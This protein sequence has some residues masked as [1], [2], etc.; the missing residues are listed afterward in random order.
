MICAR[1]GSA[2]PPG[3]R[4]CGSCGA[5]LV[6]ASAPEQ[7][8][9]RV[10]VVFC[11]VVGSTGLGE[12]LDPEVLRGHLARWFEEVRA[13][14]ERHGGSVE[15]FVGDA[16]MAVFGIPVA[17]EDDALRA[18]R[19]VTEIRERMPALAGEL[20][21]PLE[22]RMG[23]NTG[24]VAAGVGETLATG[25][26]V[27]VAARLQQAADRG[28]ILVG[29]ETVRLARDAV[30]T[31]AVEPIAVKGRTEP[32]A[33]FRLLRVDPAAE[34]IT[35]RLDAP[36]VGRT[37]ERD[38]LA[39]AWEDVGAGNRCVLVT[40]LGPA[41][42]G[43]SRLAADLLAGL[44]SEALVA[45]GRCLPYGEGIT[46]R[47]LVEILVQLGRTPDEVIGT[48][49]EST[50]LAFRRLLEEEAA[51]RPVV[52]VFDD[53]HWA[54]PL[55][56]DLVE[57]VAD[58]SRDAP[59]LLLCLARQE[60]LEIRPAWGGGKVN[61]I[62]ILL[63]PL[64]PEACEELLDELLGEQQ[65]ELELRGRILAA[66]DGNPLY[67]EEI[68][69][70]LDESGDSGVAVPPTIHALLQ[71]RLDRLD[72]TER[73]ALQRGAVEGQVFHRGAVMELAPEN[74]RSELGG[75][76]TALV[77]KEFIRPTAPTFPDDEA[78]R[79]RHL[80]IRDAAYEALSKEARAELHERFAVWLEEHGVPLYELDEIAGY[81]LEQ[82]VRYRL[83]LGVAELDVDALA[84]RASARLRAA[85]LAGARRGDDAAAKLLFRRS[86][87]VLPAGD[88]RRLGPLG[89]YAWYH[90]WSGT[91]DEKR[92]LV[93]ELESLPG[94]LPRAYGD[95]LRALVLGYG[96]S[97]SIEETRSLRDSAAAAFASA[98]DDRGLAYWGVVE[99]YVQLADCQ[100]GAALEA[101]ES[102]VTRGRRAG[103]EHVVA[104][105]VSHRSDLLFMSPLP[106]SECLRVAAE[107]TALVEHD[108]VSRNAGFAMEGL[109]RTMAGEV[110]L[111][112][113]QSEEAVRRLNELGADVFQ[114]KHVWNQAMLERAVGNHERAIEF[115]LET[116][117]RLTESGNVGVLTTVRIDRAVLL[118]MLGQLEE[119]L[120]LAHLSEQESAADDWYNVAFIRALEAEDA[121]VGGEVGR[122]AELVAAARA[123]T[124]RMDFW[125]VI[126]GVEEIIGRS[127][128][129]LGRNEEALEAARRALATYEAK[130]DVLDSRRLRDGVARL[131]TAGI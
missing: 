28:E 60:L 107:T 13:L 62:S 6:A 46:Y 81:H 3:F 78:F 49:P 115:F 130:G 131:E 4:F 105:A 44:G 114:F 113:A 127:F 103:L 118:A 88:A 121:A 76:L 109:L 48:S 125:S 37:R 51:E 30:T 32:V 38:R 56:L 124:G 119:A 68:V 42:I 128:A 66:A 43:K 8:R 89:D 47:P 122:V 35:R 120:A 72:P 17:H 95:L 73:I 27:N 106:I 123:I 7:V 75:W 82:A 34:A 40:L 50:Q 21:L 45:R 100:A 39:D 93:G 14:I 33:A 22:V 102:V 41:G 87:D 52:V 111:G 11:D 104:R 31:E 74:L 117:R 83:E 5:E 25:D 57:H 16:A 129:R 64:G 70:M 91:M 19:C 26:A 24:E 63:E 12:R 71:A 90:L 116:E 112:R 55:F 77:R 85:G 97:A 65:I 69:A 29:A 84:E 36:L 15:K 80:L 20:G 53:L 98:G 126:G 101:N 58:L 18:L 67:A 23:V 79:F 110:E 94:E 61:A 96:E 92:A 86:A 99:G 10:T 2:N 1:C 108:F 54:E 9:K 59:I